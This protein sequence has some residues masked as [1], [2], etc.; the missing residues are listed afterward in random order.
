MR[1][2]LRLFFTLKLAHLKGRFSFHFNFILELIGVFSSVSV[3]LFGIKFAMVKYGTIG[4]WEFSE[5]LLLI[6][7]F[8]MS[9]AIASIFCIHVATLIFEVRDGNFIKYLIRPISPLYYYISS[10]LPISTIGVALSSIIMFIWGVLSI[11]INFTI[12]DVIFLIYS[13]IGGAATIAGTFILNSSMAFKQ[14]DTTETFENTIGVSKEMSRFPLLIYPWYLKWILVLLIPY[15]IVAYI[16]IHFI[17]GKQLV[18]FPDILI[19]ISPGLGFFYL[20]FTWKIWN[21]MLRKYDATG[22]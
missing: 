13:T 8:Y 16:P 14:I 7:L 9:W 11:G 6:S 15:G 3:W 1:Y 4:G 12:I 19:G 17:L 5:I 10:N 20:I 2:H 22:S 21:L 18:D